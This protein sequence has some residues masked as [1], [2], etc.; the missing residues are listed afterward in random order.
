VEGVAQAVLNQIIKEY[1]G[2]GKSQKLFCVCR[3]NKGP[4]NAIFAPESYG[5]YKWATLASF[6]VLQCL[7]QNSTRHNFSTMWQEN[8]FA[9]D[10]S[11]KHL[12]RLL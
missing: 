7:K 5:I 2:A 9:S 8:T 4:P 1:R 10:M 12:S 3:K 11:H 6:T